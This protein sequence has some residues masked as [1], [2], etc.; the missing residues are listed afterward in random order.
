VKKSQLKT[1][2]SE[3]GCH[4]RPLALRP[5]LSPGLLFRLE[6]YMRIYSNIVSI[7]SHFVVFIIII[8]IIY[9]TPSILNLKVFIKNNQK[10]YK[11]PGI[12]NV[13]SFIGLY[14]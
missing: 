14:D 7:V 2:L 1:S 5:R 10:Q 12:F 11:T 6:S 3:T 13:L 9:T 8:I 4:F